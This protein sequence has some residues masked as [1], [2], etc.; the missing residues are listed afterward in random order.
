MTHLEDA[1]GMMG[2]TS[3]PP[4]Y[5]RGIWPLSR[6]ELNALADLGLSAEQ[7][8]SYF[9]MRPEGVR[10]A[11]AAL[12]EIRTRRIRDAQDRHGAPRVQMRKASPRRSLGDGI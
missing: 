11:L 8:A 12:P 9:G 1:H 2:G 3:T 5:Y 4:R 6:G 7:I 10:L